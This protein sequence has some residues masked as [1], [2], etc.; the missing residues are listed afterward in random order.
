MF[1]YWHKRSLVKV[2]QAQPSGEG[3]GVYSLV[4]ASNSTPEQWKA[5]GDYFKTKRLWDQAI[6]CYQRAGPESE[7]LAKEAH[8]YHLIQRECHQK[9]QIYLEAALSFLE[10]DQL[11]HSLHYLNGAALC[12]RNSK[13][14]QYQEAAKLFERLG[15]LD[16]AAQS[17][18]KACDFNNYARVE[19]K[20]GRIGHI[21]KVMLF[22]EA[23]K[24]DEAAKALLEKGMFRDAYR[25]AF[26]QGSAKCSL[27]DPDETWLQWGVKTAE[28]QSNEDKKAF[29]LFQ[30]AKMRYKELK[31]GNK[32][33]DNCDRLCNDLIT[34]L[35]C[36]DQLIKAQAHLLLGMLTSDLSHCR[37]AWK[38]YHASANHKIG[39][40]EAFNQVFRLADANESDDM[41]VSMCHLANETSNVLMKVSSVNKV[42]KEGL[43]FYELEKIGLYYYTPPGQDIWIGESLDSCVHERN[44]YDLDGM[45]R[46]QAS[47]VQD[48]LTNHCSNFT[49][50]WLS[51]CKF[52]TKLYC[53]L[54]MCLLNS[55]LF[56]HHQLL[57]FYPNIEV[58]EEQLSDYLHTIVKFVEVRSLKEENADSFIAV[59]ISIFTPDVYFYLPERVKETHISIVRKSVVSCSKFDSYVNSIP[60]KVSNID[61]WLKLWRLSCINK[62]S[63]KLL[64]SMLQKIEREVND[65][66]WC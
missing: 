30:M 47:K 24:Y 16:K 32:F 14:P 17:Y 48:K 8:A 23:K 28:K 10:C 63:E 3:Q 19:Q 57:R 6:L 59:A 56:E 1:D 58:S 39:E 64:H 53:K 46:L 29:F 37:T 15:Y 12:L 43:K 27:S 62:T 66:A 40:L 31:A 60:I 42:V 4:F 49:N 50:M 36:K 18:K 11:H 5:Q 25:L 35:Q 45:I 55:S 34:V 7:Y 2:V 41:I 20:R 33:D 21:K 51:Q 38:I 44:K 52:T 54:Q 9:P 61:S 26:A 65:A 13:P 22:K